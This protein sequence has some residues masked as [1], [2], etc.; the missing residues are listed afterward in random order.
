MNHERFVAWGFVGMQAVLIAA[1]VFLPGGSDWTAPRWLDTAAGILELL[2]IV[3]A[4]ASL[5]TLGRSVSPLPTP[6]PGGTLR[7][8]GLYRMVRHPV[9]SGLFAFAVGS[10][11]RSGSLAVVL[12][13]AGLIALLTAKARWEERRLC[14][15]YPGYASYAA[16]TPRFIPGW[17]KGLGHHRSP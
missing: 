3:V 1:I 16:R 17:P 9:Y 6:V 15:R 11:I 5:V 12:A 7:T 13:A 2:G 8:Q 10:T 4:G 14:D